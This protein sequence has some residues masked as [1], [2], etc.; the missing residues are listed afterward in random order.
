MFRVC[1]VLPEL[2]YRSLDNCQYYSAGFLI[3]ITI[4]YKGAH[5]P[6]LIVKGPTTSVFSVLPE[7][8]DFRDW[9]F[10]VSSV[11][12]NVPVSKDH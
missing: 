7:V 11:F 8:V 9:L 5:N 3:T 1:S 10:R 4:Y 2:Y 6:I 12:L